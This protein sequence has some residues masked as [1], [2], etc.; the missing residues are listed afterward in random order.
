MDFRLL[1]PL[2]ASVDGATVPLGGVIKRRLVAYLLLNANRVV[3]TRKLLDVLWPDETPRTARK[4]LGNAVRDLRRDLAHGNPET[5]ASLLTR[6]PGYQLRIEP[7]TV[8]LFRFRRA[9]ER[10]RA[11]AD[12][13]AHTAAARMLRE[14]LG[15]WRGAALA[16]L[17]EARLGWPELER[18]ESERL[19]ALEDLFEAELTAGNHHALLGELQTAVAADPVRERLSGQLMLALYRCGRQTDA[20]AVFRRIRTELVEQYGLEPSREL[21][22]LERAI[23]DHA[24]DLDPPVRP[25]A[26]QHRDQGRVR[27]LLA[28]QQQAARRVEASAAPGPS[29]VRAAPR[30]APDC[31]C[32]RQVVPA[33]AEAGGRSRAGRRAAP[34]RRRVSVVLV[35]ARHDLPGDRDLDDVQDAMLDVAAVVQQECTRMGGTTGRMTAPVFSALFG[36]DGT[37]RDDAARAV[38]AAFAIRDRLG[39]R[40]GNATLGVRLHVAVATGE[41]CLSFLPGQEDVPA[42]TGEVSDRCF[43][44]LTMAPEGQVRVCEATRQ[45]TESE[46]SYH[47]GPEPPDGWKAVRIRPAVAG[48]PSVHRHEIPSS[49]AI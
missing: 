10:G 26:E 13:G 6:A 2:Q 7:D 11:E 8:D 1:G 45:A 46:V 29:P 31:G 18:L 17:A 47:L 16:D 20:L 9:V 19:S 3:A 36:V 44:L 23:L 25:L 32:E 24:P 12:A 48:G 34:R 4:M 41:A 43:R 15:L 14:A 37:R 35:W 22:R 49:A 40:A 39:G 28:A 33:L 42:V 27:S 21:R 38:R 5:R 30:P